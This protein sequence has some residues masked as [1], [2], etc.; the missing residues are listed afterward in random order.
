MTDVEREL[1]INKINNKKKNPK[2]METFFNLN[3]MNASEEELDVLQDTI[4]NAQGMNLDESISI[5][6]VKSDNEAGSS[7]SVNSVNSVTSINLTG[8]VSEI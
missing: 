1:M 8:S 5:T 6:S 2:L 7:N 3:G 4:D